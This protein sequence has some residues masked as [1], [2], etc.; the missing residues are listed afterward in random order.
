MSNEALKRVASFTAA[1]KKTGKSKKKVVKK[2]PKQAVRKAHDKIEDKLDRL[3]KKYKVSIKLNRNKNKMPSVVVSGLKKLSYEDCTR[4]FGEIPHSSPVPQKMNGSSA[5][6]RIF[7]KRKVTASEDSF[8]VTAKKNGRRLYWTDEG[9]K[10]VKASEAV[11]LDEE[12]ADKIE[13]R[14]KAKG[15]DSKSVPSTMTAVYEIGDADTYVLKVND[16][17]KSLWNT[18]EYLKKCGSDGHSVSFKIDDQNFGFDGDG[19]DKIYE[20][21]KNNRVQAEESYENG[22]RDP[23]LDEEDNSED[24]DDGETDEQA[25]AN[26]A[27]MVKFI[28]DNNISRESLFPMAD[29]AAKDY[30]SDL[31]ENGPIDDLVGFIYDILGSDDA[32]TGLKALVNKQ[33][34]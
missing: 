24:S 23:Y 8:I 3:A 4:L 26:K 11:V 25:D 7:T 6:F 20:L 29:R 22:E 9:F 31:K 12:T 16:S 14:S 19:A 33:A 1:N 30:I 13:R 10:E 18:L 28:N 15:W 17:D 27:D 21:N 2:N 32:K 5:L 34:M